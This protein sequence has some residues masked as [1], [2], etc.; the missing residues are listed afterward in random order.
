MEGPRIVVIGAGPSG[1]AAA[2]NLLQAGFR[3][4]VV[5][6]RQEKVGGNWVYSEEEGH[7]SVY[8]TTHIISSKRWSQYKDFPMPEEYPDYPSHRQLQAYFQAYAEH[9][10]VMSYIRFRTSVEKALPEEDGRWRLQIRDVEGVREEVVD[11]LLVA[12]GHHWSPNIPELPGTFT[13]TFMHSHAYKKAEPFRGKRVLVIGGGNSACDIAVETGRI[14][15]RTCLSI[16]R[17]YYFMPKFLFGYPSDTVYNRLLL[18]LPRALRKKF[19]RL[20]LYVVQ[21]PNRL[22]GLPEPDHE[23]LEVHPTLNSELL[24]A[25]RHGRVHPRPAIKE[26]EGKYVRF[27]D[28]RVEEFDVIIAA[29]GYRTRY[30][31][32]DPEVIDFSEVLAS[33]LYLHVF[34]PDHPRLFFIGLVQP[35]GCIWPLADYQSRLVAHY[36]RGAW[37]LP[38][39]VRKRIAREQKK[40]LRMFKPAHRHAFEV[41]YLPYRNR[42]I[43]ELSKVR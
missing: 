2:K 40:H 37:H 15:A 34:H 23:P 27:A 3:N 28:D 18:P 6:D 16:R 7:S 31:F 30:P 21:G 25:I 10:G 29:T 11:Y 36:I 26:V 8:E 5:Y 1:I 13:G 43:R 19:I 22:Y 41:D 14:S 12:S 17:G 4:L 35:L 42:L 39:D 38:A 9:F 32:F 20:T 24:Y 33:P